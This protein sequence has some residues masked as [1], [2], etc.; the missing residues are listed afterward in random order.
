MS[1]R[2]ASPRRSPCCRSPTRLSLTN[3]G[4]SLDQKC[5]SCRHR[6]QSPW[7]ASSLRSQERHG[8]LDLHYRHQKSLST[9]RLAGYRQGQPSRLAVSSLLS[10]QTRAHRLLRWFRVTLVA[11]GKF[12]QGQHRADSLHTA[13][14]LRPFAL[15]RHF[16]GAR[17]HRAVSRPRTEGADRHGP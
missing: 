12:R 16:G 6:C 8:W 17:G 3:L 13:V 1:S 4:S 5:P 7:Q 10:R 15:S 9:Q 14:D 11:R 2:G